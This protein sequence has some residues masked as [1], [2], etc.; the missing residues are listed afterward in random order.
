MNIGV[1]YLGHFLLTNLL[2][3]A[4]KAAAPSRIITLTHAAVPHRLNVAIDMSKDRRDASDGGLSW[5][6]SFGQSQ[7]ANIAFTQQLAKQLAGTRV[8]ANCVYPGF[9]W[10]SPLCNAWGILKWPLAFFTKSQKSGA[11]TTIAAALDPSLRKVSGR[12]LAECASNVEV[13]L[14]SGEDADRISSLWRTSERLVGIE[15]P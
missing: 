11:Q 10:A 15:K 5:K 9:V 13:V 7:L 1:N 2:L 6:Q 4:L 8:T 3:D 12:Y 14:G